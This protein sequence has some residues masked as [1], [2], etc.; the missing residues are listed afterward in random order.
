MYKIKEP[1]FHVT[2]WMLN[3][4]VLE[5]YHHSCV[6]LGTKILFVPSKLVVTS[7]S[8]PWLWKLAIYTLKYYN[9]VNFPFLLTSIRILLLTHL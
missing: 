6:F 7:K 3:Q 1:D 4:A 8:V 9:K 2:L 5:L